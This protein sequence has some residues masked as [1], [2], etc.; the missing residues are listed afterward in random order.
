MIKSNPYLNL[1]ESNS[2]VLFSD[3]EI[4]NLIFSKLIK[5]VYPNKVTK[6]LQ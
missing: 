1:K 5:Y 2:L 6:I 4:S 3:V